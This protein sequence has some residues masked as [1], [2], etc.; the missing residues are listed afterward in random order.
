M[1]SSVKNK[2][3]NKNNIDQLDELD[4]IIDDF[5]DDTKF[6]DINGNEYKDKYEIYF[7]HDD[8]EEDYSDIVDDDFY[9]IVSK[10]N[11]DNISNVCVCNK[12]DNG[13]FHY[14]IKLRENNSNTFYSNICYFLSYLDFT[15][16]IR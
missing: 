2:L 10:Y 13:R 3:M 16:Q 14:E 6:I 11:D 1:P 9:S 5:I 4:S 7:E 8:C 15:K 12:E